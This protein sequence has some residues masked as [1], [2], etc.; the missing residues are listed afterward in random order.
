MFDHPNT[1][2]LSPEI[3]A[4]TDWINLR[5]PLGVQATYRGSLPQRTR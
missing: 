3:S 2:A 5:H 1:H 4:F